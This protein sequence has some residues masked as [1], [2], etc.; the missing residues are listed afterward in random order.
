[1]RLLG[2][3][4]LLV[5]WESNSVFGFYRILAPTLPAT[6][7]PRLHIIG[8]TVLHAIINRDYLEAML[9][10][11]SRVLVAFSVAASLGVGLALVAARFRTLE[12][13]VTYPLEFFRQLPAISILPFAIV[14]FGIYSP[15]KIA[16]AFFGCFLPIYVGSRD[17]LASVDR[18]LILTA[19]AYNW[20]GSRLLLGIMLPAALPHI[21][22][23]LR[24]ALAIALILVVM[25]EMLVGGD[26]LGFRLIERERTFDFSGLYAETILLGLI[27]MALNALLLALGRRLY[28]WREESEWRL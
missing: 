15:M 9:A 17:A 22:A 18:G 28:Y 12:E 8:G 27:G 25:A 6:F 7:F 26:G 5:L 19:R 24:I 16:V 11:L 10:T 21:L 14:L 23:S 2:L 13:I 20:T 3:F 4:A 1:M